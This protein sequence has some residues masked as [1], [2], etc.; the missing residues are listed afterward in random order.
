MSY[1]ALFAMA[2]ALDFD[3]EQMDVKTAFLFGDV[4]EEIYVEQPEGFD[5][6]TPSV[7]RLNKAL[8]GLKQSPRIWYQTLSTFLVEC[9]NTLLNSDQSVF[10]RGNNY[11]AVYVSRSGQPYAKLGLASLVNIH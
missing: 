9:S 5:D 1:K 3:I 11:I 2:A 6:G 10:V 8:Y 4:E 7:C